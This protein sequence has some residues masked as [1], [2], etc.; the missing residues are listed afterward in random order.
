MNTGVAGRWLIKNAPPILA[1]VSIP[2]STRPKTTW[3]PS[4]S[5]AWHRRESSRRRVD[6]HASSVTRRQTPPSVRSTHP[7]A[8]ASPATS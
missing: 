5:A 1:M 3:R 6:A 4:A 8:A 7:D 2:V